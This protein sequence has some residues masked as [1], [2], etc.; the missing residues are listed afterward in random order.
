MM[1]RRRGG[2]AGDRNAMSE[3]GGAE[4]ADLQPAFDVVEPRVLT[5][6]LVFN[7]PHSGASYP[8]RFLAASRLDPLAPRR[9]EGA[10]VAQFFLPCVALG[11]QLLRA[12]FP[13]AFLD[14]NREPFELDPQMFEGTL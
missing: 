3:Q 9:S 13:R 14:L 6:P 2:R 8:K 12:H 4:E 10:F 11:A 7:S 1:K 5:T